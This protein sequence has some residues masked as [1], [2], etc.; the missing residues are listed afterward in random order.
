MCRVDDV[1]RSLKELA[2]GDHAFSAEKTTETWQKYEP[3]IWTETVSEINFS[4]LPCDHFIILGRQRRLWTKLS[5]EHWTRFFHIE[6][7]F[8]ISIF[9]YYWGWKYSLLYHGLRYIY[10]GLLNQGST[11][12]TCTVAIKGHYF[13]EINVVI[14]LC[15]LLSNNQLD[16][17]TL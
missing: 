4:S 5:L 13:G 3:I 14:N 7:L 8:H 11:A 2:S 12:H 17:A 15:F 9:Y 16:K 1:L 10:G 6:V